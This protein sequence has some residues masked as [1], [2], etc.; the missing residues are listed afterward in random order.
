MPHGDVPNL[1]GGADPLFYGT[2]KTPM[3][4]PKAS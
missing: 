2:S 3:A 1:N 4:V